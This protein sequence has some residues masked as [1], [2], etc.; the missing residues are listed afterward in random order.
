[1]KSPLL[2][3]AFEDVKS[4]AHGRSGKCISLHKASDFC[5]TFCCILHSCLLADRNVLEE[6]S[7]LDSGADWM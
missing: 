3:L 2:F 5:K 6:V 1:M 7:D 4:E